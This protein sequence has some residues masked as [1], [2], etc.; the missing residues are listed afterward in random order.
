MYVQTWTTSGTAGTGVHIVT[1]SLEIRD[2]MLNDKPY[3]AITSFI[4]KA[5]ILRGPTRDTKSEAM[6]S[7]IDKV[8]TASKQWREKIKSQRARYIEAVERGET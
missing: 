7:F 1:N 5:V 8:L 4:T 3:V 6:E 2:G